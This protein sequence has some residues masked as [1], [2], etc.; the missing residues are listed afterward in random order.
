MSRSIAAIPK[1]SHAVMIGCSLTS[2]LTACIL[3]KYFERVTIVERDRLPDEPVPRL[4][5]PQSFH[6]HVLLSR[7]RQIIE[8]LFPGFEQEIL[9]SG[10]VLLDMSADAAWLTFAGWSVRFPSDLKIIS[11]SRP[12]IDWILYRRL[13]DFPQIQFLPQTE[14][15]GLIAN[16]DHTEITGVLIQPRHTHTSSLNPLQQLEANFVVDTSG[17]T[18]KASQWLEN[19]GYLPPLETLIDAHLGYASR[20]YQRPDNFSADWESIYVQ[21]APPQLNRSCSI[22]PIEGDRWLFSQAGGDG[23]Y[24]PTDEAGFLEFAR[25]FPTSI[26]YE[27]LKTA[28]P[29]SPIYSYRATQNRWRHYE[30]LSRLPEGFVALGDAVCTFNPV[31]GQGMTAA[32]LG[33]LTLDRCLQQQYQRHPHGSLVSLSGRFQKQLAQIIAPMW[34]LAISEDGRYRSVEGVSLNQK[35]KFI[36]AYL[37]Q[38]IALAT[39]DRVVRELFLRV[40]HLLKPP[41]F[42]VHPLIVFKVIKRVLRNQFILT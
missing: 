32:A 34:Q 27:V 33:A 16:A 26:L 3:I 8:E 6:L 28:K 40:F 36:Q 20:V 22:V 23:E 1:N 19:L 41:I 13:C 29:L 38:I 4:G 39:E 37:H 5:V 9:A 35:T 30:H 18:S 17:R 14:V 11:C 24:P 15:K 2:L 7:G 12:L 42:L 10:A 31:Y 25:Q 21:A